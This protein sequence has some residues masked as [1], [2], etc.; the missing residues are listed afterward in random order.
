MEQ[1]Q[2]D[3]W[4]LASGDD[5][6][7]E[8]LRVLAESKDSHQLRLVSENSNTPNDVLLKLAKNI[9]PYVRYGV[10]KNVNSSKEV[11]F[12]VGQSKEFDILKLV[13]KHPN[14]DEN[15]LLN[16]MNGSHDRQ[17]S[18][19]T[20]ACANM[21]LQPG[22]IKCMMPLACVNMKRGFALN[23]NTP[24]ELLCELA[25]DQFSFIRY[26]IA[27]RD[28]FPPAVCEIIKR[29]DN[30]DVQKAILSN[31]NIPLSVIEFI[32]DSL[33]SS[34]VEFVATNEAMPVSIRGKII[35]GPNPYAKVLLLRSSLLTVQELD[36]LAADI[37]HIVRMEVAKQVNTSSKTLDTLKDDQSV[38]VVLEVIRN[39]SVSENILISL[40]EHQN[41]CI[42]REVALSIN[43]PKNISYNLSTDKSH[44][45]KI[46]LIKNPKVLLDAICDLEFDKH[47][48]VSRLAKLLLTRE[49]VVSS[50]Y[51]YLAG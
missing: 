5:S 18:I 34:L 37:T 43:L 4:K 30:I 17:A 23:N 32:F 6:K 14:V 7:P 33:P 49:C 46:A 36:Y 15:D 1:I 26:A 39:P 8:Q 3:L 40:S 27:L 2:K 16:I 42:R 19:I 25:S 31:S 24:L 50:K 11:L 28:T 51:E 21:A 48:K 45:V 13:V 10:A 20:A 9:H 29:E 35:Y 44:H 22:T 38:Q 41:S 47:P 12:V